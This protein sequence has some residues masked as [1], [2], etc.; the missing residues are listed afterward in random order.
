MRCF[1]TSDIYFRIE[2]SDGWDRYCR[3][4]NKKWK[5]K[6]LQPPTTM[7]YWRDL[8]GSKKEQIMLADLYFENWIK[9]RLN[10]GACLPL[11]YACGNRFIRLEK[12]FPAGFRCAPLPMSLKEYKE[13][14]AI[15]KEEQKQKKKAEKE[16]KALAKAQKGKKGKK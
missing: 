1:P 5:L 12:D 8:E 4:P 3:W 6:Q 9:S 13:M 7:N 2:L 16:K 15:I 11:L 14:Q 10:E